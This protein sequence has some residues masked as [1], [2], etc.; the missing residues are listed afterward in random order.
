MLI[1]TERTRRRIAGLALVLVVLGVASLAHAIPMN[2]LLRKTTNQSITGKC[3][4]TFNEAVTVTEP[5]Q[6]TPVVVTWSSDYQSNVPFKVGISV[7]NHPCQVTEFL[8]LDASGSLFR[9]RAIQWV[10]LPSDGLIKGSNT[11]TLCGGGGR[12][13]D[14]FTLGFRTLAVT[15]SK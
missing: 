1:A 12:D 6:L 15:I 11:I 10:V 14:T 5:A 4:F 2:Q 3:C 8:N 7:N 9:S 13:T